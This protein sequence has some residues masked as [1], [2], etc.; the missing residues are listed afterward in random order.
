MPRPDDPRIAHLQPSRT[1][2]RASVDV[3]DPA[4]DRHLSVANVEALVDRCT[5]CC[6]PAG[7][8][9]LIA[10]DGDM[11]AWCMNFHALRELEE[12]G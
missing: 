8:R 5:W 7:C 2:K 11:P 1:T 3:P 10:H 12:I 6:D 4:R 9:A